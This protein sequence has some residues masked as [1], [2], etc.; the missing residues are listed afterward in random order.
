MKVCR[1]CGKEKDLSEYY[2]HPQMADG[3]LNICKECVKARV[4]KHREERLEVIQA[5]DRARG[6]RPSTAKL[7]PE[8]RKA[9]IARNPEKHAAHLQVEYAL[10]HGALVKPCACEICDTVAPLH[11]HHVDYDDPL[12]V[13]WLCVK[14]HKD[15]HRK[16]NV[17]YLE[18]LRESISA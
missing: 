12:L 10:K 15:V 13:V 5:Y 18:Y 4:A 8:A 16:S 1:K 7:G 11:A 6:C 17:V 9:Y 14:C 3:H 2:A